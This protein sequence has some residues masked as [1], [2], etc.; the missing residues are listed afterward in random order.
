MSNDNDNP[1]QPETIFTLP[2]KDA[3]TMKEECTMQL[4]FLEDLISTRAVAD[5]ENVDQTLVSLLCESYHINHKIVRTTTALLEDAT[6]EGEEE[7]ED[8]LLGG[9]EMIILQTSVMARHFVAKE[10][11]ELT[12]LS[13]AI[14]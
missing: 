2:V 1:E 6:R 9:T 3:I 7:S 5:L 10:L 14:H 12:G 13:T 4:G 8:L 11:V